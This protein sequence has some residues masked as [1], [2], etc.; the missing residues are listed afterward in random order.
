MF[1][2]GSSSLKVISF[3]GMSVYTTPVRLAVCSSNESTAGATTIYYAHR[4]V[5]ASPPYRFAGCSDWGLFAYVCR[6]KDTK[7]VLRTSVAPDPF[8]SGEWSKLPKDHPGRMVQMPHP[9]VNIPENSE[10]VIL[11]LRHM[12][13]VE[14]LLP[15]HA[16]MQDLISQRAYFK[17]ELKLSDAEIAKEEDRQAKLVTVEASRIMEARDVLSAKRAMFDKVKDRASKM[18]LSMMQKEIDDTARLAGYVRKWERIQDLTQYVLDLPT[19][20]NE[21]DNAELAE[22]PQALKDKVRIVKA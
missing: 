1:Y 6:D 20:D 17:E 15:A 13:E 22:V 12:N 21:I 3:L 5:T 19:M 18:L 14:E 10:V 7:E 4:Y 16:T 2:G 9:F 11:D 8:W